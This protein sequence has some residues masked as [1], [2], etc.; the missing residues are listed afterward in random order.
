METV[1]SRR[2][3]PSAAWAGVVFFVLYLVGFMMMGSSP[4][5]TDDVKDSA[6][7]MA[8]AWRDLY[9]DSGDRWAILIGAFLL[10]GAVLALVVFASELRQRLADAGA[11]AAGRL[12]FAASLLFGAVTLAGASA[13]A[14]IPGAKQLGDAPLPEGELNYMASQ[15]GYAL[16]LLGGGASAALLLVTSGRAGVRTHVLPTWLGWAGVVIGVALFFVGV[17]FI[18]MALFALWVLIAAITM[19]RKPAVA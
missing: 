15:L 8:A 14:W 11:P 19:I 3:V 17:L 6:S 16:L 18:P 13:M 5:D 10:A 1:S 4:D 2:S 9:S 7:G 12:A